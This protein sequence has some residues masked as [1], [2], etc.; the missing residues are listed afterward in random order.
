MDPVPAAWVVL[1][2]VGP[3][4]AGPLDS[5]RSDSRGRYAFRYTRTGSEDAILPSSIR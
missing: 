3:D 5:V 2:R 1:H 4:R